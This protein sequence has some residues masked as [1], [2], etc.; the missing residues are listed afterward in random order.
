MMNN[1]FDS[2]VQ[3][4]TNKSLRTAYL[5][6]KAQ[7]LPFCKRNILEA[8][9]LFWSW[10]YSDLTQRFI[11]GV[12]NPSRTIDVN[13]KCKQYLLENKLANEKFVDFFFSFHAPL[14]SAFLKVLEK[15]LS[16]GHPLAKKIELIGNELN[17]LLNIARIELEG[18]R[19]SCTSFGCLPMCP[20]FKETGISECE[21]YGIDNVFTLLINPEYYLEPNLFDDIL[22][23]LEAIKNPDEIIMIVDYR[24]MCARQTKYSWEDEGAWERYQQCKKHVKEIYFYKYSPCVNFGR[25]QN[26][27]TR[28]MIPSKELRKKVCNAW[29]EKRELTY[30]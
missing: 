26:Q 10:V 21:I 15:E 6:S 13:E 23:S 8:K 24:N 18:M 17:E 1:P 22:K 29:I 30:F 11:C 19:I 27:L 4:L 25:Y 12:K 28:V 9:I 14:T 20:H 5:L 16:N 7:R 3:S 2:S